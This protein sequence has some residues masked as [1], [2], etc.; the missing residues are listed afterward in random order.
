MAFERSAEEPGEEKVG[1]GKEVSRPYAGTPRGR[2][3]PERAHCKPIVGDSALAC[4]SGLEHLGFRALS[5]ISGLS[6][7]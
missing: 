5:P 2:S 1:Q 3:E 4:D 7:S 6:L